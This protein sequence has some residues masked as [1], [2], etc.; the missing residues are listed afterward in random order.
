MMSAAAEAKIISN[1]KVAG[2][3]ARHHVAV[4]HKWS[5][6]VNGEIRLESGRTET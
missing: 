2:A 1:I 5:Y 3:D 6:H 4:P